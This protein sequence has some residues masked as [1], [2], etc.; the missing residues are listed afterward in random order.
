MELMTGHAA[1]ASIGVSA[2]G[3]TVLA[4]G[5]VSDNVHRGRRPLQDN[6]HGERSGG[7]GRLFQQWENP[8]P[9]ILGRDPRHVR[10]IREERVHDSPPVERGKGIE[11][12][13][14]GREHLGRDP[15]PEPE[16]V[17]HNGDGRADDRDPALAEPATGE[18][19]IDLL[20]LLHGVLQLI[21]GVQSLLDQDDGEI[22][23]NDKANGRETLAEPGWGRAADAR[24]RFGNRPRKDPHGEHMSANGA[25]RRGST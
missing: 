10:N 18:V 23:G 15:A 17:R 20:H 6:R 7:W 13:R 1:G 24:R 21:R 19:G 25:R 11:Q 14:R 8:H 3:V 9:A 12:R 22:E 2:G 4:D 16:G 5:S